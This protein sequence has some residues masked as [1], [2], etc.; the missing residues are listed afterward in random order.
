MKRKLV[1]FAVMVLLRV[2]SFSQNNFDRGYLSV[3]ADEGISSIIVSDN[4][5]V[6]LVP[7]GSD[8]ISVKVSIGDEKKVD[9]RVF[10]THLYLNA[11]KKLAP[12]ERLAVIVAVE[13]LNRLVLKGNA[14]AISRGILDSKTLKISM[15]Q[16]ARAAIRI[17]GNIIAET[18]RKYEVTKADNYSYFIAAE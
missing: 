16:E 14:T 13:D 15:D 4:I 7:A 17:N 11:T 10:D 2:V 3:I 5:D 9:A 12:G 18:S 1:L 6:L 8:L